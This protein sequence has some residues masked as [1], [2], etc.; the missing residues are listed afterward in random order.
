MNMDKAIA[1]GDCDLVA[2]LVYALRAC[3]AG[4]EL[5][6]GRGTE[7][8]EGTGGVEEEAGGG[9]IDKDVGGRMGDGG[10][11]VAG[12][13]PPGIH[14]YG[15]EAGEAREAR[16]AREEVKAA[17]RGAAFLRGAQHQDGSFTTPRSTFLDLHHHTIVALWSLGGRTNG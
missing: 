17:E 6:R 14:S 9:R 12:G 13:T 3:A 5:E 7:G 4:T 1:K 8:P 15:E 2:E 11:E 16:E 10:E